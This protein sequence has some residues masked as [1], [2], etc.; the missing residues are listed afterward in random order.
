MWSTR[1]C[2]GSR[3]QS[4]SSRIPLSIDASIVL[5]ISVKDTPRSRH[6]TARGLLPPQQKSIP[7]RWKMRTLE[8]IAEAMSATVVFSVMTM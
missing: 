1:T 6:A 8:G 7:W 2:S 5:A 4:R 3:V